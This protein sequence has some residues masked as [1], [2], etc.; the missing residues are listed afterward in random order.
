MTH[1]DDN[2]LVLPPKIASTHIVILPIIHKEED[3][4][5]IISYSN[6]LAD[7]LRKITYHGQSL[8]VE[9]D[10]RELTGGEKAWSWVKKGVP[11]RLEVG[12]KEFS[13]DSVFMGR[14]D[15]EYKD[16][17]MAPRNEFMSSVVNELDDMQAYLL[18][19]ARTM[20]EDNTVTIHDEKAF[21]DYF[22]GDGGFA[23][24]HWNGNAAL[25]E[26]IKQD[27]SVTIRCLPFSEKGKPGK[28]IFTGE[29][30]EQMV[31]FAKAY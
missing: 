6:K 24:A 3:H 16:K 8:G 25:E 28:C 2:G 30:S 7:E 4:A 17:Q 26:K 14:R 15:K 27:L 9:V 23:L 12:N 21:Y 29:K 22:K 13:A 10:T 1:S 31:V 5:N 18:K 20:R 11:I 19:R